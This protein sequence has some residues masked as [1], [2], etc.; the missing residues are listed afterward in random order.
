MTRCCFQ[1]F[2]VLTNGY[3]KD[4]AEITGIATIVVSWPDVQWFIHRSD[5]EKVSNEPKFDLRSRVSSSSS[6]TNINNHQHVSWKLQR[7][8]N[9]MLLRSIF[10]VDSKLLSGSLLV[11]S[12]SQSWTPS[13]WSHSKL[14]DIGLALLLL[15]FF[16]FIS[17]DILIIYWDICASIALSNW[18]V[19]RL[20]GLWQLNTMFFFPFPLCFQFGTDQNPCRCKVVG[21]TL[22]MF[23]CESI[24]IA[25]LRRR[26]WP[27][28]ITGFVVTI[29]SAVS[30]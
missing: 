27:C 5:L 25:W 18:L 29:L 15:S 1:S 7:N 28:L 24:G 8:S 3:R 11:K 13:S 16:P 21:P 6:P 22:G 2:P 23:E 14:F 19:E 9:A 26:S 12:Q 10:A 30:I 4:G 17:V 20:G